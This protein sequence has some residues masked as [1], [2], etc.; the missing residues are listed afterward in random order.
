MLG[1]LRKIAG[2]FAAKIMLAL[3]VL[4]FAIWGI[5]DMVR[6]PHHNSP[7]VTVGG[8]PI[9]AREFQNALRR[10]TD[11]MRRQFGDRY[12][13]EIAR[14]FQPERRALQS[15][16]RGA[17]IR[18]E[19]RALGLIP[20]D[21]DVARRIRNNPNFRD[22]KGNFDK[23][24][25]ES[26]LRNSGL[27]EKSYIESVRQ[28]IAD[29][30]LLN[31]LDVPVPVPD[32]AV[33]ALYAAREEGRSVTVYTMDESS[34]TAAAPD[35]NELEAYYQQHGQA[36]STPQYRRVSVAAIPVG[37]GGSDEALNKTANTLEDALAGGS[38]LQEAAKE[39]GLKVESFGPFDASGKTPDGKNA[40]LPALDKLV[41]TA[42]KTEEKTESSL[43][44]GKNAY[45]VLRVEEITPERLRPLDEVRASVTA[46]WQREDRSARLEAMAKRAAAA[47]TDPGAAAKYHLKQVYSGAM[48]RNSD[49]LGGI[50]LPP[51]LVEDVF[52]QPK[53]GA[54]AAYP[55][56][57]G[58]YAMASVGGRI[59]APPMDA[60]QA[61]H[62]RRGLASDMS[63]ELAPEYLAYLARKYPISINEELLQSVMS[64]EF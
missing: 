29:D 38:T 59:A 63:A 3:L 33:R 22:S 36:F 27:T 46:A 57:S 39:A 43:V 37:D 64:G 8:E 1:S 40:K 25:L 13:P 58:A 44:L 20:G 62:I 32:S 14:M 4:S 60:T 42:F 18:Q 53:G 19:T 35:K 30:L 61:D 9:P 17:L 41:E 24:L 12:S 51:P 34:V 15:L 16:I 23:R 21:A 6:A 55:L 54:T 7:V 2:N 5:G 52:T 26:A 10:E 28:D 11:A 45:Y 50:A 49:K 56:G 47:L 48:K 31:A